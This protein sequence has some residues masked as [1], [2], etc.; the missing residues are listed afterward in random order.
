[1]TD[2]SRLILITRPRFF[3]KATAL[4]MLRYFLENRISSAAALK[5]GFRDLF[6]DL[7]ISEDT[8]FCK[9]HRGQY[10]TILFSL[11]YVYGDNYEEAKTLI[12]YSIGEIHRMHEYLLDGDILT[13]QEKRTFEAIRDKTAPLAD[14]TAGLR[15]LCTYLHRKNNKTVILLID[16]FE[17]P[18]QAAYFN[19]YSDQMRS[20]LHDLLLPALK[21]NPY[22]Y[23]AV[24][25]G[26]SVIGQEALLAELPEMR[27]YSI[28]T[29]QRY[30]EFF[31]FLESDVRALVAETGLTAKRELLDTWYRGYDFCGT[32]LYNPFS[33]LSFLS[34]G[35]KPGFYWARHPLTET[36][37]RIVFTLSMAT[38]TDFDKLMYNHSVVKVIYHGLSY[39]RLNTQ[40]EPFWTLLAH[41]GYLN[42]KPKDPPGLNYTV[43]MPN[44]EVREQFLDLCKKKFE[45]TLDAKDPKKSPTPA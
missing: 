22:L 30:T 15:K 18:Y 3:G 45:G 42:A 39:E 40:E 43:R 5:I 1:M 25:T 11:G 23:K 33:V 24:I 20:L 34:Q 12:V 38:R 2:E 8:A 36:A 13:D 21:D 14:T 35:G 31:G 17:K 19:K 16:S 28:L 7:S 27:V 4:S 10:P 44:K 32:L 41:Y 26:I 9:A 29:D 37:V 6:R